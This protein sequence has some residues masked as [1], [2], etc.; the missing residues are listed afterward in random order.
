ML[1]SSE[2]KVNILHI[3]NGNLKNLEN[4]HRKC[5]RTQ[6]HH[7]KITKKVDIPRKCLPLSVTEKNI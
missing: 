5:Q 2:E 6:D 4:L 1:F 7:K 3:Y